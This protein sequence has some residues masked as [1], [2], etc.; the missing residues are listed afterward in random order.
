[1]RPGGRGSVA[2]VLGRLSTRTL[3][4]TLTVL[5]VAIGLGGF[6][7]SR[8]ALEPRAADLAMGGRPGAAPEPLPEPRAARPVQAADAKPADTLPAETRQAK[9]TDA[10][11]AHLRQLQP[12]LRTDADRLSQIVRR[13][14]GEAHVPGDLRALFTSHRT[15]SA[16]LG[17]HHQEYSETKERLRKSLADQEEEFQQTG[18]LVATKLALAPAGEARRAEVV[19]AILERCLARGP[20]MTITTRPDG[21]QYTVRGRS[22]RYSGGAAVAEDEGAA[23][24]AFTSFM[25]EA[26]VVTRCESMKKRAAAIMASAEKLSADALAL[27]E[28]TTLP[29]D[30]KYT[31]AE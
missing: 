16:D 20:G 19:G 3:L 31:N 1:M 8:S 30:C 17:N 12:V 10:R 21:Y 13:M 22:Q 6:Y 15:L 14:R 7:A 11:Q 27:A 5:A 29:G 23:F 28:Q 2:A 26:E 18:Q 4:V 25:P 9:A 24:A